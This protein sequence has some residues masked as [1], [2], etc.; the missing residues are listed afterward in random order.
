MKLVKVSTYEEMSNEASEILFDV[1]KENDKPVIGLA[2]GSTPEGTYKALIEKL[3]SSDVNQNDITT[4]N[5]DEYVGLDKD[6]EQSYSYYMHEN[7][8][9]HVSIPEENI[10][11]LNGK[12]EDAET[13]V[14]AYEAAIDQAGLDVQLLGIG[15][16][17]HIAFNEP[18]T[19]FDSVTHI[20][21]LTP[22][23]IEDN[24]RFFDDL[25]DVPNKAFTMGL[26]SIMKAEK[27]VILI[28]GENKKEALAE[29]LSGEVS[30]NNP[31][32]VLN[33]HKDVTIIADTAAIGE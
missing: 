32:S 12:A 6:H 1:I 14:T 31:A 13:E 18:G 28:S 24:S 25:K 29:L 20:V 10:H 27:I 26:S 21:D 16:N 15:R 30:E 5:L 3:N 22:E 19:S 23:T 9:N 7:F 4:F 17:G 8:F 33:N 11:L 2:T